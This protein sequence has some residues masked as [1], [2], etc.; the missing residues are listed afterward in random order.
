MKTETWWECKL[1]IRIITWYGFH[2]PDVDYLALRDVLWFC[3]GLGFYGTGAADTV[4]V[5]GE[6]R[7]FL[8]SWFLVWLVLHV[9]VSVLV[10]AGPEDNPPSFL[11]TSWCLHG[12]Q[13]PGHRTRLLRILMRIH[14]V[15]AVHRSWIRTPGT[16]GIYKLRIKITLSNFILIAYWGL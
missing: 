10:L 5:S 7:I 15:L 3:R 9:W 1:N 16:C 2:K 6:P 11:S 12:W 8:S 4:M 13:L 14:G